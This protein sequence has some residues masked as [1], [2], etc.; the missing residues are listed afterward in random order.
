M[1]G[2]IPAAKQVSLFHLTND[3]CMS[4][5]PDIAIGIQLGEL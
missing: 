1:G 4:H 3:S 2:I 5:H